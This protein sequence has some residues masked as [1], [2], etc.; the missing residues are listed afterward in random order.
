[1]N[2]AIEYKGFRLPD[3]IIPGA[4]KSGTTSLY[5]LLSQHPDIYFPKDRKEP[6]YFCFEDKPP[7]Y[8]DRQFNELMVWEQESY[9]NLYKEAKSTQICG[10]ASTSYLYLHQPS[11]R[12]MKKLYGDK[13]NEV[14]I[15]IILR[16]PVDRAYSHYTYLVRNGFETRAFEEAIQ[17][18]QIANWKRK[19]WGFDY[20]E[21]GNYSNQVQ[22]YFNQFPQCKVLLMEDLR[23]TQECINGVFEF[24]EVDPVSVSSDVKANPSGIPKNRKMVDLLRKNKVLKKAVNLLP[25][26]A[27]RKALSMRDK[28]MEKFM[29][30]PELNAA[31]RKELSEYFTDD[32]NK[33]SGLIDRDLTGWLN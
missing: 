30:K 17:P 32:I 16:N 22:A 33:L 20:L 27:K 3:F 18:A 4:A 25:S 13:L 10:D 9:L 1:M 5:R 23:E 19:R 28:T 12:H 8:E 29:E 2:T 31:T 21:Y 11:I 7:T 24:L 14:K 15:V 26:G 6:F